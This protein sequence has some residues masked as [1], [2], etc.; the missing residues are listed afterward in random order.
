[1]PIY[2]YTCPSC[3]G[4]VEAL[5]HIGDEAPR[6]EHCGKLLE[7]VISS[8]SFILKGQGW[9]KDGYSSKKPGRHIKC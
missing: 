3:G 7:K 5:K 9:A 6:C 8:S 1:M 2:E 4:K